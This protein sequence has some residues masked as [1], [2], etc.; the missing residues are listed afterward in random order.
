[1][2]SL[3]IDNWKQRIL[4]FVQNQKKTFYGFFLSAENEIQHFW[5]DEMWNQSFVFNL[6]TKHEVLKSEKLIW[7]FSSTNVEHILFWQNEI[8]FRCLFSWNI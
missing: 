1:M 8:V 4:V 7:P 2:I 6:G 3:D 5:F